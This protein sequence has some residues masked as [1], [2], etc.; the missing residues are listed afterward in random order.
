[1]QWNISQGLVR[2]TAFCVQEKV[3]GAGGHHMKQNKTNSE[4]KESC[5][6]NMKNQFFKYKNGMG[7][8]WE[9]GRR[10][11]GRVNRQKE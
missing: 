6:F 2:M 4:R 11:R 5:F 9:K 3:Y 10:G 7:T 8:I 1:M